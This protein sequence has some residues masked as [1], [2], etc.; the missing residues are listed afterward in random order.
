MVIQA[1]V[2]LII[3]HED[4]AP[5]PM[6]PGGASGITWG[7]GWDAGYQSLAELRADW[8]DEG[9]LT[10]PDLVSQHAILGIVGKKGAAA[11][12]LLKPAVKACFCSE[13]DARIVFEERSVPKYE[14][15]TRA[16]FPGVQEL[17]AEVYGALV[18]LVFNRG[19]SMGADGEPSWD[20]RRE[21]REIRDAVKAQEIQAIADALRSM[22]R[23]WEGR[24]LGGLLRRRDD[25]AALVERAIA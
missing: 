19:S 21:M 7:Y 20:Q 2:D 18:S 12:S 5:H 23:I 3:G 14:A 4:F 9:R 11:W 17:P 1:A 6:W 22:K 10:C 16:A 8:L 24:N 15:L 13:R 25:E